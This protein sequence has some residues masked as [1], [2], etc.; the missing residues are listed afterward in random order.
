[1]TSQPFSNMVVAPSSVEEIV[2]AAIN[3]ARRR[4]SGFKGNKLLSAKRSAMV[5]LTSLYSYTVSRIRSIC[6]SVPRIDS[7]HP[8]YRELV[9]LLVDVDAFKMSLAKLYSASKVLER[10]SREELLKIKRVRELDH[11]KT[12]RREFLGRYFSVIESIEED[13]KV[14]RKYQ[15]ALIKLQAINP[16]LRTIVVAGP[17]NVGK[18]SFVRA[19]SRA[20][21]EVREYPFTTKSLSVGHLEVEGEKIQI[22][23]TPGL[24]DRPLSLRNRIELQAILA[25]KY[26]ADV[27]IF[28]LDP[29]E[30][31][32]FTLE[33]QVKVLK[34]VESAFKGL[35]IIKALNKI[36]IAPRESVRR[37]E[38]LVGPGVYKISILKGINVDVVLREALTLLKSVER[39]NT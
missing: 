23:D 12:L 5:Y 19:V 8:F 13:L 31:C 36:D 7:L 35:P 32:G 18:S 30:A 3:R 22:I 26:L 1:M 28:L 27:I 9:R 24:L 21:P 37:A 17:P 15:L 38:E 14:V 11:V 20:K 6:F 10:I 25:L 4:S 39:L 33:Q 2:K 16:T 29:S 34:D